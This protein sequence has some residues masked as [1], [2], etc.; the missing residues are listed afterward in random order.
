MVTILQKELDASFK[1]DVAA[2]PGGEYIKRCF[3]CGVCSGGC[4]INETNPE[5]DPR[6]L[7]RM[8]LLGMREKVLSSPSLWLCLLCHNCSFH[9]PQDVRTSDIV[10]ALRYLAVKEKYLHPHFLRKILFQAALP[11]HTRLELFTRPLT[12]YQAMRLPSLV[13]KPI[14]QRRLSERLSDLEYMLPSVPFVPLRRKLKEVTPAKG[15]R[16]QRV[17][18]FLGCADDLVF[19]S[20]GSAT[21]SLLTD[22]ACE[23]VIPARLECCGMPCLG[24]GEMEQAIKLA[25]N[26]IDA[27]EA[28][29]VE[30]IITDCGTCGSFL[31]GYADLL[32]GEPQY[33]ERA[34]KFSQKVRDISEF[35][36]ER[37]KPTSILNQVKG[38]VT[39]HDSCHMRWVQKVSSQPRQIL[40]LIPGLE[41]VEMKES[42]TCC[43]GAGSYN[44]THYKPSMSILDRKMSNVAATGANLVA[45]GCPGCRLQ[46]RL[47]VKRRGLEG[48]VVHPVELLEKA[49]RR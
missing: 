25:K 34:E 21:V 5:F 13:R 40:A 33:A 26:N 27:F 17:G 9:C 12:I 19:N 29:K 16:K 32:K 18:F 46:L 30:Y 35:L 8:V 6:K 41:L 31:K 44:L 22:N 23:V 42:D 4:L 48:L 43:G 38:K 37:I 39:Y 20:A 28:F 49:C 45:S 15:E 14:V 7:I 47:G 2:T 3:A 10:A 1:Y 11:Y 24:Y 36:V